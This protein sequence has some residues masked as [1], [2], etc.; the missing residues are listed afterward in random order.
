MNN[1]N[2]KNSERQISAYYTLIYI[3]AYQ[4]NVA[5]IEASDVMKYTLGTP[6]PSDGLF[7]IDETNGS[8]ILFV[9][10]FF[11]RHTKL[12]QQTYKN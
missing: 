1:N 9:I 2:N 7:A 10:F 3:Q 8:I 6:I 5:P 12:S 4:V 11:Y